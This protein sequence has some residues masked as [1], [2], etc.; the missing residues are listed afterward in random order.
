[1]KDKAV[2]KLGIRC[3]IYV[4]Q[5]LRNWVSWSGDSGSLIKWLHFISGLKKKKALRK[6]LLRFVVSIPLRENIGDIGASREIALRRFMF[7]E[8]RLDKNPELKKQYVD[9]MREYETSGHM[10]LVSRAAKPG[11]LVYHIPHHCVTKKFRMVFDASCRTYK[12]ISLNEVQ[13]LG[14]KLQRDLAEI[15][16]RFRRHK[17]GIIGDIQKMFR[18]VRTVQ[19]QWDLQRIFWR[20]KVV[21]YGMTSSAF[22]AVRAVIQCARDAAKDFPDASKV[23]ENDLYMDDCA[24]GSRSESEAIKLAKDIDHVLKGGGFEMKK[25]KSN[26]KKLIEQM[27]LGEEEASFMFV[28][29][30]KASV[31]GL[32]WKVNQDQ[33]KIVVKIPELEGVITKRKILGCVAQLYDPNGFISPVTI[34][35]KIL[36]QDLW[37]IGL[38]WDEPVPEE[39]GTRFKNH[40]Q[41]IRLLENFALDRWIGTDTDEKTEIH[42]FSDASTTAY[43]AVIYIRKAQ[44]DGQVKITLLVSKTRV[45]PMKTVTVPRLELAAAE[46]LSRNG[47][48]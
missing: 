11:D 29:D 9:F 21:T 44:G 32:K 22:N 40:W 3:N 27:R 23:I 45:A 6:Y 42:G 36:I 2:S 7:L 17:I 35:G 47:I 39:I 16:L 31:L 43:G 10:E 28:D 20:L 13:M 8:K 24:S 25:W 5:A 15:V 34:F 4:V 30:E 46:L 1:M 38:D 26:S 19:N 37:R 14:E 41:E 12:G 33:F 18:Q 48:Y